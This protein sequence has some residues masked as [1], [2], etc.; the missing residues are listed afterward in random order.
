V[1]RADALAG[2][3]AAAVGCDVV[4]VVVDESLRPVGT[5]L[6][7]ASSSE[8]AEGVF[9]RDVMGPVP[10]IVSGDDATVGDVAIVCAA[11]T[12]DEPV[13]VVDSFGKLRRV[14]RREDLLLPARARKPPESARRDGRSA[15]RFG[16]DN[17]PR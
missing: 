9:V 13:A 3:A 14:L 2:P 5:L 6:G 11:A 10:P 7:S 17:D 12:L 16:A 15:T 8:I 4:A 1:V